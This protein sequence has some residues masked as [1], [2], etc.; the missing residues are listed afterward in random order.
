MLSKTILYFTEL[1]QT[2]SL[3]PNL[4]LFQLGGPCFLCLWFGLFLAI[5][6]V[7]VA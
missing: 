7:T 3:K 6:L 5:T 2:F 1:Y 4:F